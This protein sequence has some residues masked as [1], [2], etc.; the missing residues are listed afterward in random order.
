MK[1]RGLMYL[2]ACNLHILLF[3][4]LA[5]EHSDQIYTTFHLLLKLTILL[6]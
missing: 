3:L 2:R 6:I 1:D 5:R 4:S